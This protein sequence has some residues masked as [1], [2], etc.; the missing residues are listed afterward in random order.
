MPDWADGMPPTIQYAERDGW[1]VAYQVVGA[2]PIDILFNTSWLTN[3]EVIWE[4]PE[5]A[6][7]LESL[8]SFGRLICYDPRGSGLSDPVELA[9]TSTL[10]EWMDDALVVLDAVDSRQTAVIGDAEG[11]PVAMMLAASHP[12][13]VRAL[14]LVNTFA[15]LSRAP[16]YPMGLAPWMLDRLLASYKAAWGTGQITRLT[17]PAVAAD[18]AFVERLGRYER[19]AMAPRASTLSWGWMSQID[20]RSILPNIRAPTLVLHRRDGR[21]YR[22]EMGRHLASAIEGARFVELPGSETYPFYAGEPE[23]VLKEIGSFLTGAAYVDVDDR[24]LATVLFTDIVGSTE[25][26]VSM[27]DK[28]WLDLREAHDRLVRSEITRYRGTEVDTAGDGFLVT[29]DGPARAIRCA[30]AIADGVRS[31]GLEIR[32]GLHTGEVELRNDRIAGVAVHLAAR[33]VSKAAAGEVL[34]SGTV[35]DLVV[36]SGIG[37]EP[38]GAHRLKGIPG[39]WELF[40]A[41]SAGP[42][43]SAVGLRVDL[44]R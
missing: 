16:D 33:V 36:G 22:I 34:V 40:A 37:F 30:L 9:T 3:L 8:A 5:R 23:P 32:A 28:D 17:A 4:D 27:G 35:R 1:Y 39:D 11:G 13:R 21:P 25:R 26:A 44:A 18:V 42:T 10:E 7:F 38:R 31:H 19:L 20:V 43:R 41:T 12:E 6:R 29:F 2:G 14:V 24:V 15:R